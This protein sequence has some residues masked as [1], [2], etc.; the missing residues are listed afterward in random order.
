MAVLESVFSSV[1]FKKFE[2]S[3]PPTHIY[4]KNWLDRKCFL[5][6][7]WVLSK[8][9][10][11]HLWWNYFL[12]KKQ[13]LLRFATLSRTPTR[14]WYVPKRSFSRNFQK[15]PFKRCYRFTVYSLQR[16]QNELLIKSLKC[17][18]RL[19]ENF[20]EVISNRVPYQKFTDLQTAAFSLAWF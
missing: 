12:V 18:L 3:N 16:Y 10:V 11:R 19:T 15:S 2:L 8:L 4:S 7:F 1:P 17:T 6:L 14:A 9:D 13:K 20:K 5:C